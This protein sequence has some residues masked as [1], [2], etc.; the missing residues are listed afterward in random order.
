MPREEEKLLLTP[1]VG[2]KRGGIKEVQ[3]YRLLYTLIYSID[4]YTYGIKK[5]GMVYVHAHGIHINVYDIQLYRL[6]LC[7]SL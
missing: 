1:T 6:V 7:T 5:Y 2:N 3:L 4:W